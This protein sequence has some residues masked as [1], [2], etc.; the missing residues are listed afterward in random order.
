MAKEKV[1]EIR[2]QKIQKN[3]VLKGKK[4]TR[5]LVVEER[6]KELKGIRKEKTLGR[7]VL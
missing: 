5:R 7:D 3:S 1:K 2:K 6:V 4:V